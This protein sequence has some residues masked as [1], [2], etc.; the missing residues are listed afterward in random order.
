GVTLSVARHFRL[1]NPISLENPKSADQRQVPNVSFVRFHDQQAVSLE[2]F[3]GKV[4]LINFWASWCSACLVEMPSINRLYETLKNEGFEVIALNVDENPN[5]VVPNLA[6][7][8]ELKFPVYLEPKN[9][10]TDF[11]SVVAIPYSVVLGKDQRVL[12]AES[13]ER[14]W[15]APAIVEELRKALKTDS[16]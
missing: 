16:K 12:W 5:D 1:K 11:F 3:K 4:V 2:A 9:T 15:S 10:L 8:L 6:K 7:K 14:D 13:G